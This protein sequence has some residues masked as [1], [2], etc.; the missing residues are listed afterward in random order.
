MVYMIELKTGWWKGKYLI[1]KDCGPLRIGSKTRLYEVSSSHNRCALGILRWYGAFRKYV[2]VPRQD[3]L[4]DSKCL[5]EVSDFLR[6]RNHEHKAPFRRK[7]DIARRKKYY[8]KDLTSKQNGDSIDSVNEVV[9]PENGLVE[10]D[11]PLT[12]L[13]VELGTIPF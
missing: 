12:P 7:K 8:G 3:T 1:I 11:Q 6:E 13:E 9:R 10:G 2:F 5:D 4:F